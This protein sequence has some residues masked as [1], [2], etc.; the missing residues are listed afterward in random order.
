M[1]KITIIDNNGKKEPVTM[2]LP[3]T[4][5]DMIEGAAKVTF[6]E[7]TE[8]HKECFNENYTAIMDVIEEA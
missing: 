6:R 2:E 5:I 3:K 4:I 1:W 7:N 8:T